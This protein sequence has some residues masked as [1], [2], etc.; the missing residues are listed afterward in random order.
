MARA[1]GPGIM[2]GREKWEKQGENREKDGKNFSYCFI[3]GK[4]RKFSAMKT[5]TSPVVSDV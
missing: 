3:L 4:P 5:N 2:Q 1:R